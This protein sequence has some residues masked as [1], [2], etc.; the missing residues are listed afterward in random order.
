MGPLHESGRMDLD[1]KN[2][3]TLTDPHGLRLTQ[4]AGEWVSVY[5]AS[6]TELETCNKG[7]YTARF[8]A[9]TFGLFT[10]LVVIGLIGLFLFYR[11]RTRL[12]N[13][14]ER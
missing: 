2:Q 8:L 5:Q 13:I 4:E 9:G 14:Q 3:L 1:F 6:A 10:A 12:Q 11:I 7:L